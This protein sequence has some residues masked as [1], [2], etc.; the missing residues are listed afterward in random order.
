VAVLNADDPW[1]EVY[2]KATVQ[3]VL[4]YG[5]DRSADVRAT[6]LSIRGDGVSFALQSFAG[7]AQVSLRMTGRFSVYNALAAATAGLALGVPL[8]DI[9][10]SLQAI[11]GVPGA[12]NRLWLDSL[13]RFLW[14]IRIRRIVWKMRSPLYASLSQAT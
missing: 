10:A 6:H 5:I 8:R 9:L 13:T 2:A 11:E 12:S 14:I 7:D 4:T 1:S 3:Q